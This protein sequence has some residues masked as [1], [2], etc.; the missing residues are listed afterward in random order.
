MLIPL[1]ILFYIVIN[2]DYAWLRMVSA[3][4]ICR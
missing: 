4:D 2:C 3:V 1:K